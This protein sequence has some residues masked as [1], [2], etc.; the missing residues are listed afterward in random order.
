MTSKPAVWSS[1]RH[2]CYAITTLLQPVTFE[3]KLIQHRPLRAKDRTFSPLFKSIA[4]GLQLCFVLIVFISLLSFPCTL[5]LE[6][7]LQICCG[8]NYEMRIEINL[9][10]VG[11]FIVYVLYQF[12]IRW[13]LLAPYV[14]RES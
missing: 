3:L 11:L 13:I 8:S 5:S 10:Y 4:F 6:L 2:Y 9:Q 1:H 14:P 12:Y 7:L